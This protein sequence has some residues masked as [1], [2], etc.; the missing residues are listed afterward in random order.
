MK[1]LRIL[2]E[3]EFERLG[4]NV[5][6]SVDV[7]VIAATN[8]DLRA[9]LEKGT[10]REDLYY[11]LNVVPINIPPLRERKEDIP[12]LALHFVKKLTKELGSPVKEISPSA[13]DRLLE[14]EWPGN[15]RELENTHGAKHRACVGRGIGTGRYTDRKR[16]GAD[17]LVIAVAVASGGD[18]A[19]AMGADDDS[20]GTAPSEREQEPGRADPRAHSE[21]TALPAFPNGHGNR[22]RSSRGVI[23]V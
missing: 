2:Q 15:V 14:Y 23:R 9:A 3:R 11:R 7:R 22:G 5:T 19:R 16:A 18:D 20:R 10:F 21:R 17:G 1:L 6:R 4:S 13:M 12:F 8:V